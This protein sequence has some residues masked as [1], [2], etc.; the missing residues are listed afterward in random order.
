MQKRKCSLFYI[1]LINQLPIFL[2]LSYLELGH[3]SYLC[4]LSTDHG[5][6]RILGG[7]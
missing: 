7:L 4:Y 3:K 5:V 6:I 1:D 2:N